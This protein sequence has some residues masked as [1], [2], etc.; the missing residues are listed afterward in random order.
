MG[1]LEFAK[2]YKRKTEFRRLQDMPRQHLVELQRYGGGGGGRGQGE[3][4]SRDMGG[5][6]DRID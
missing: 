3:Q 2:V 1:V 5:V 6:D 4:Q